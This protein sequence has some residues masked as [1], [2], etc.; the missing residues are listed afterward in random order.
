MPKRRIVFLLLQLV[1]VGGNCIIRLHHSIL[2]RD[3]RKELS[4]GTTIMTKRA[5]R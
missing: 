5:F 2:C 3:I 1:I 4:G